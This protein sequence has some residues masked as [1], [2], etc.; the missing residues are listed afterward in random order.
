VFFLEPV[1]MAFNVQHVAVMEQSVQHSRRTDGVAEDLRPLAK[2]VVGSQNSRFAH[3][4]D[5]FQHLTKI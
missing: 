3:F 5:G 4:F 2:A 1:G